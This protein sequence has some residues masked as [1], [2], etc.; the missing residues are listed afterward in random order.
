MNHFHSPLLKSM[1]MEARPRRARIPLRLS[2]VIIAG[3]FIA[4][5]IFIVATRLLPVKGIGYVFYWIHDHVFLPIKG[6]TYTL[7]YPYSI[8]W[9]GMLLTVLITWL[10]AYLLMISFTRDPHI[11]LLRRIVRRDVRHRVLVKTS[12]WLKKWRFHPVLLKAVT[13][14]ERKKALYHLAALPLTVVDENVVKRAIRLTQLYIDLN[15]LPPVVGDSAYLEA[16]ECWHEAYLQIH[17]GLEKNPGSEV[18]K[19]SIADLAGELEKITLPLLNFKDSTTF[20]DALEKKPGFDVSTV[21]TDLLFLASPHNSRLAAH[22]SEGQ[23]A[24]T[25]GAAA[26]RLV[27]SMNGRLTIL[28]KIREHLEKEA[29]DS[30]SELLETYK[31]FKSGTLSILSRLAFSLAL[32]LSVLVGQVS[33]ALGYMESLE[34]LDFVLN[35]LEPED[36]RVETVRSLVP[37]PEPVH[38]RLCAELLE[39]EIKSYEETWQQSVLN[40]N[41]LIS[42]ADFE[43]ARTRVRAL[44]HAAGPFFDNSGGLF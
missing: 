4:V 7:F 28:E 39:M 9:W 6:Y 23:A 24:G 8:S 22:V 25:A 21:L 2:L 17:A 12:K 26:A 14:M 33:I 19:R 43:L 35:C 41:G 30:E 37:L 32:D 42:P 10:A 40:K 18:L 27:G 20:K 16:I 1:P 29:A 11:Y 36:P 34:T 13:D 15:T 44:Y 31:G 5:P 38:Y 3:L